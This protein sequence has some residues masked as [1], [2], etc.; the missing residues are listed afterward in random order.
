MQ[1]LAATVEHDITRLH[2]C[3][4]PYGQWS[5][6][7]QKRY[8]G[9]ARRELQIGYAWGIFLTSQHLQMVQL[10][11]GK[12]GSELVAGHD[13]SLD[14]YLAQARLV[15]IGLEKRACAATRHL[16]SC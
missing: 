11:P 16:T 15:V 13:D 1:P 9:H 3:A 4:A 5:G 10:C 14:L 8:K 2:F 6:I 7:R 12:A